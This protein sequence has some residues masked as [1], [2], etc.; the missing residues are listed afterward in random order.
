MDKCNGEKQ[1]SVYTIDLV[2]SFLGDEKLKAN[3]SLSVNSFSAAKN[4]NKPPKDGEKDEKRMPSLLSPV[5]A[6]MAFAQGHVFNDMCAAMWFNYLLVYL[7]FVVE[8]RPSI[9]G[10][11]ILIGQL[12]DGIVCPFIGFLSDKMKFGFFNYGR[13]K[14]AHLIGTIA[15]FL[16][17]PFVF[18]PVPSFLKNE[19]QLIQLLYYSVFIAVFQ[20]G[21][22]TVQIAH[23]AII[24]DLTSNFQERTWLMSLRNIFTQLSISSVFVI[25]LVALELCPDKQVVTSYLQLD[26]PLVD[27]NPEDLNPNCY[28]Q[29]IIIVGVISAVGL[30]ETLWYH[31]GVQEVSEDN[32]LHQTLIDPQQRRISPWSLFRRRKFYSVTLV[33]VSARLFFNLLQVFIPAYVIETLK[34]PRSYITIIPLITNLSNFTTSL[35]TTKLNV[36]FGRKITFYIGC[37]LGIISGVFIFLQNFGDLY[38]YDLI[39]GVATVI[40]IATGILTV[41]ALGLITDLIDQDPNNG[42]FVYGFMSLIEKVFNGVVVAVIQFCKPKDKIAFGAYGKYVIFICC[43]MPCALG[44]IFMFFTPINLAAS[45]RENERIPPPES[46]K[47]TGSSNSENDSNSSDRR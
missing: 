35:M 1:K 14:S 7:T 6:Q 31:L 11:A 5:G 41:T 46:E 43:I 12:V 26:D 10:A 3:E 39:F 36:V 40:G 16:S 27:E 34:L 23:L 47:Q 29:F 4:A 21:W 22:A 25:A 18:M 42:A 20:V 37:L 19:D 15:V 38:R 30:V 24:T 45:N 13:R 28:K 33:Y 2:G 32:E 17:F 44:I 9:V 8:F